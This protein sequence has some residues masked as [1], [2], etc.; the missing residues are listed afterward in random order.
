MTNPSK[1]LITAFLEHGS[2]VLA[3]RSLFYCPTKGQTLLHLF[4]ENYE[5]E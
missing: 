3:S 2:D 5:G 4:I 1:Y